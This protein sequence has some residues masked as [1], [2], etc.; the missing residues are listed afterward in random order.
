MA[1]AQKVKAGGRQ[2]GDLLPQLK[3]AQQSAGQV[4]R[5]AMAAIAEECGTTLSKV[6]GVATFY[7]FLTIQPTARHVVR[8]CHSV[9]CG[10][11]GSAMILDTLASEFG[12]FPGQTTRDGL[13][14][15]E[16][17]NCIGACDE[18]P[19][20]L[21]NDRLHGNLTPDG[22]VEILKSYR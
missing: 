10:L 20:M 18:A 15:L 17:V 3:S 19:A 4:S 6:Y 21:V 8:V 14:S 5:A 1:K 11:Q 12:L 22:I 9:P 16:V 2:L 7:S 13:F